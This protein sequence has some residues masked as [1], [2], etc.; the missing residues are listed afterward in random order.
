MR[1]IWTTKVSSILKLFTCR[2]LKISTSQPITTASCIIMKKCRGNSR[3]KTQKIFNNFFRYSRESVMIPLK[4]SMSSTL[5][6]DCISI[7]MINWR[8]ISQRRNIW[9]WIST[10]TNLSRSWIL[11]I[12]KTKLAMKNITDKSSINLVKSMHISLMENQNFLELSTLSSMR[13]PKEA[14]T[15]IIFSTKIWKESKV[16]LLDK[17]LSTNFFLNKISNFL[18]ISKFCLLNRSKLIVELRNLREKYRRQWE[19]RL[20]TQILKKVR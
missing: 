14:I 18:K 15:L 3:T 16:E 20:L 7:T 9:L 17:L 6:K 11:F 4:S 12:I 19:C 1:H 13:R 8:I 5:T 10:W 2:L